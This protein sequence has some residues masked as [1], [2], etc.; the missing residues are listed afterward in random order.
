MIYAQLDDEGLKFLEAELKSAK[1][2]K[3]YRRLKIIHLS[4]QGETV[5]TLTKTLDLSQTTIRNYIKRYNDGGIEALKRRNS[6]GRPTKIKLTKAEWE[7]LL[8]RS[9]CQFEKLNTGARNWTQKLL[10][11]YFF[12]YYDVQITA[13]AISILL[14]RL[15]IKWNRG[16]LKVTS[17]DPLYTV[18]RERVETLKEK[19]LS[20]TLNSHDATDADK[21]LPPKRGYL[22]FFDATDLH[23]CPDVGTGYAPKGEQIKVDSPGKENPW[24]ALLGSLLYPT[25]EGLYTIH[26][27]KRH[28]EVQ[29]HLELLIQRVPDAFWFVVLD[30]ASAHTTPMLD[31]FREQYRQSIEFVFQPTYS[32][33]LNLIEKLWWLMRKQMTK[34]QFYQCLPALCEA[35][36]EWLEK[37]P[38][39]QFCSLMG[40]NEDDLVFVRN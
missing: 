36:V 2:A 20:G 25:G 23:W 31:G 35:I 12:V 17:P 24:C 11:Q 32:P 14:K 8:H 13:Q 7:E 3:W 27:H 22:S 38:F 30:N 21:S 33:H 28:E 10:V 9:P 26:E 15:G 18:K 40:I 34:N 39:S 16:K 19:A 4:S 29:A 6:N 1:D 5:P 37:L